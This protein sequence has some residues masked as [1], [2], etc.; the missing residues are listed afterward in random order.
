V[1]NAAARRHRAAAALVLVLLCA[2]ASAWALR[3][4]G[5]HYLLRSQATK[6]QIDWAVLPHKWRREG[7]WP[8]DPSAQRLIMQLREGAT[9][10]PLPNT[11]YGDPDWPGRLWI[12]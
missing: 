3:A 8:D 7:R 1:M 11:R 12:D 6:H 9:A 4:A 10:M 2:L 5:V